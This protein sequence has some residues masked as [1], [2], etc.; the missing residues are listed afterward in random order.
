M[1]DTNY[2]SKEYVAHMRAMREKF[3]KTGSVKGIQGVRS[4]ILACWEVSY[5][6]S[7]EHRQGEISTQKKGRLSADEF[8]QALLD[9]E[10]LISVAEPYMRLLHS[11][12]TRI[13]FG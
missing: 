4:E 2:F 6:Y 7:V 5:L 8:N 1:D 10:A 12:W 9:A 11:F 13:I 3:F